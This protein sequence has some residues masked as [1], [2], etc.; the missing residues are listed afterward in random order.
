MPDLRKYSS[1]AIMYE[2]NNREFRKKLGLFPEELRYYVILAN[3]IIG[4][5]NAKRVEGT[6]GAVIKDGEEFVARLLGMMD[7]GQDAAF[8]EVL[9]TYLVETMKDELRCCC[10]NCA[11]FEE[12]LDIGN[13]AVGG[14]FERRANGEETEEL[15]KEIALQ[16]AAAF[17]RTPHVDTDS[18]HRLC[19]NFRHQYSASGI[20]EVFGRYTEIAAV[21]RDTFG[22][23]YRKIQQ[24]MVLLNMEF[25]ERNMPG[26]R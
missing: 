8:R 12:C 2:L 9:E 22:I 5:E 17:E 16:V 18:A 3:S 15:K 21:L 10:P 14:L 19:E 23:D 20:G 6:P 7:P 1:Y 13:L 4:A 26:D 25:C 11:C 24:E